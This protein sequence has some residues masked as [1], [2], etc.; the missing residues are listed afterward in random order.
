MNQEEWI[1][2]LEA[3]KAAGLVSVDR[4]CEVA[5]ELNE[6]RAARDEWQEKAEGLQKRLQSQIAETNGLRG[7]A[8]HVQAER[9]RLRE[10]NASLRARIEEAKDELKEAL[11]SRK[12]WCEEAQSLDEKLKETQEERNRLLKENARLLAR[13]DELERQ[14]PE[15]PKYRV[16]QWVRITENTNEFSEGDRLQ[17][18]E[19]DN[20]PCTL[21][22][23]RAGVIGLT[24]WLFASQFE[25]LPNEPEEPTG[26]ALV[27][28]PIRFLRDFGDNNDSPFDI[29]IPKGTKLYL[30]KYNREG[31]CFDIEGAGW[32]ATGVSRDYFE[33]LP[34]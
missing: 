9:D 13:I 22:P 3:L 7:H 15:S 10:E 19:V 12:A 34:E 28:K 16:G 25:L 30:S 33:L 11:R 5:A 27:G 29:F 14:E 31:D 6:A 4:F 1:Q 20:D 17:I 26:E 18:A 24:E 8:K 21:L 2:L 32:S 23:V